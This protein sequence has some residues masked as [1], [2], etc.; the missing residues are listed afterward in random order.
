V[1]YR[2]G[3]LVALLLLFAILGTGCVPGDSSDSN[4]FTSASETPQ[5]VV[6]ANDYT[7]HIKLKCGDGFTPIE[8]AIGS[9][10]ETDPVASYTLAETR[11]DKDDYTKNIQ[12]SVTLTVKA[13]RNATIPS[14]I[15]HTAGS[16]DQRLDLHINKRGSATV[17]LQT[18]NY[19][20]SSLYYQNYPINSVTLCTK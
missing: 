17:T 4:D 5:P 15:V 7:T 11:Q 1:R 3:A 6:S 2:N 10:T 12:V 13:A 8:V 18:A 16:D 19:A 20:L 9:H 14:A